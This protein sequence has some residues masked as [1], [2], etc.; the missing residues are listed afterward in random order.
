M[1]FDGTKATFYLW[2]TQLLG[3]AAT[4]N[5]KRAILGSVIIPQATEVLD[6]TKD[7]DKILLLSR[8]MNDTPMCL[9]NLSL[10]DKISQM[11]LYKGITTEIPDGD[12]AKVWKNLFKLCFLKILIL[13]NSLHN[14][15]SSVVA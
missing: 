8:K 10:T 6:E 12:A 11:A 9:F 15:T 3:S 5:F 1:P 13:M 4:E 2:A 7:A 14:Y